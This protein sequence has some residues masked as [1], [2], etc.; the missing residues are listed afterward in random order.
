MSRPHSGWSFA[1][2]CLLQACVSMDDAMGPIEMPSG[3]FGF[4]DDSTTGPAFVAVYVVD[5]RFVQLGDSLTV[6]A[7]VLDGQ[8]RPL[9][10]DL[11]TSWSSSNNA[12]ATVH[13]LPPMGDFAVV[14]PKAVGIASAIVTAQGAPGSLEFEVI[15]R[16]ASL[17]LNPAT[18]TLRV[19]DS[20][21][22]SAVAKSASG[23]VIPV[24]PVRYTYDQSPT[25]M[26][27]YTDKGIWVYGK[28]PGTFTI[29]AQLFALRASSVITIVNR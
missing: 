4:C 3:G 28:S 18:A 27:N 24:V 13:P 26:T 23:Q 1:L 19:G 5:G 7:S 2:L 9:S 10:L 15:P 21:R 12:V 6:Q 11:M 29:E 14:R 8:C 17:V 16:V 25:V 20:I 22:V